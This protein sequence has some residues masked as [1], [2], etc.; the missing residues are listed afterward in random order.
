MHGPKKRAAII[1]EKICV[2]LIFLLSAALILVLGIRI[3]GKTIE[4][5]RAE[6]IEIINNLVEGLSEGS[7]IKF[8]GKKLQTVISKYVEALL[9]AIAGFEFIPRNDFMALPNIIN[10]LPEQTQVLSFVYHGHNLT[11]R[12][13]QPE[14]QAVLDMVQELEKRV[15]DGNDNFETVVYSYYISE[16]KLC[17]AEITLIAYHY[18]EHDLG[19]EL[20]KHFLPSVLEEQDEQTT[21]S[22][23]AAIEERE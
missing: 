14:P 3:A 11:I 13:V 19:K 4:V 23:Q 9:R 5:A 20:E 1:Y 18:D 6:K 7:A 2:Q 12:T 17:V 22:P 16:E 10:S 15:V 21:D 8:Q